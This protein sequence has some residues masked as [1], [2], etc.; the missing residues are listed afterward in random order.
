MSRMSGKRNPRQLPPNG[1][2]VATPAQI[3]QSVES[4]DR[5]LAAEARYAPATI[6]LAS[7][8]KLRV[9]RCVRTD[10]WDRAGERNCA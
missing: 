10:L 7:H 5:E 8:A 9:V 2:V 3:R 6:L 1:F 4:R